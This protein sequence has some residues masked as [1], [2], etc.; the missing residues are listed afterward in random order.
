MNLNSV[1]ESRFAF[2]RVPNIR[3]HNFEEQINQAVQLQIVSRVYRST[4]VSIIN[5]DLG[6]LT[7][8]NEK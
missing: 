6:V 3:A 4:L 8:V 5:T 1:T 7:K 2:L